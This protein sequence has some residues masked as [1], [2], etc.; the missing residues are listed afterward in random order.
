MA[1]LRCTNVS[2]R[3]TLYSLLWLCM[4]SGSCCRLW[5]YADQVMHNW[6]ARLGHRI[7]DQYLLLY[8][9]KMPA[10]RGVAMQSLCEKPVAFCSGQIRHPL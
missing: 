6:F 5:G 4:G 3:Q 9:H 8:S 7:E 10:K 2:P 1:G